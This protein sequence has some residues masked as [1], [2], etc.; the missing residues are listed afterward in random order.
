MGNMI[1]SQEEFEEKVKLYHKGKVEVLSEYK[2]SDK[3]VDIVYH[4]NKHGDTYTTLNAKNICKDYFLPCKKCQSENKSKAKKG[5][6]HDK[7]FYY[8]RL[9]EYCES[10]GGKLISKEWTTAKD[11]YE[12]KCG[13][14][15]HP[16]FKTTADALYSGKHWCPYCSGRK[17]NF[18]KEAREII[19]NKNGELLSTYVNS[20]TPLKV[21]CKEHNYIWDI[22]LSNLRK[23][24]WC[25]ICNMNYNEKVLYDIFK[26]NNINIIPQYYFNDLI[27]ETNECLRFDFGV[28]DDNDKLLYLIEVDD[29]EHTDNHKSKRRIIAKQRDFKKDK[30]CKDNNII[31][32]RMKVPFRRNNRDSYGLDNYKT[33]IKKYFKE[34]LNYNN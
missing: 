21:K 30:Y 14:P 10:R 7:E 4:C 6:T 34:Q 5:K 29:E 12:F 1:I 17:G 15:N 20:K 19:E 28:L 26:E 27:G 9:K 33:Y 18:E 22:T 31:L 3:P 8:N 25:P 2:G 24:R 13:N 32:Y 23:G 16:T 11:I